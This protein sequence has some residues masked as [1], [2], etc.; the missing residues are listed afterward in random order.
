[1]N[2]DEMTRIVKEELR[3]IPY[4]GNIIGHA[5]PY[6]IKLEKFTKTHKAT[7]IKSPYQG[8]DEVKFMVTEAG[9]VDVK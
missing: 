1:M 9:V 2:Q 6:R 4:G 3:H 5:I 8:N 7:I